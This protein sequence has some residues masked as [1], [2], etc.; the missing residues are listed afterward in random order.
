VLSYGVTWTDLLTH[1]WDELLEHEWD[2]PLSDTLKAEDS[3]N[4]LGATAKRKFVRFH[5]DGLR[6]RQLN[7]KVVFTTDGSTDT[8]PVRLFSLTTYV[9]AKEHVSKVTT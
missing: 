6:F 3:Q 9:L 4:T 7:F 1:L 2:Q 5:G 8:A